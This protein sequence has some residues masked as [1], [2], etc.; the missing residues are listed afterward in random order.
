M[1]APRNRASRRPKPSLLAR[2]SQHEIDTRAQRVFEAALPPAWVA[3]PLHEPDYGIDYQLEVF[4]AQQPVALRT[5][6]QLKGTTHLV[7][8]GE[9][10]HFSLA[11]R[12]L[13]TYVD[14][15]VLPVFLVVVDVEANVAYFVFLQR[16][17]LEALKGT[18]WRDQESVTIA[19]HRDDRVDETPRLR[20][21]LAEAHRYNATRRP[22]AIEGAL[23]AEQERL[24]SID[25]RFLATIT[26]DLHTQRVTLTPLEPV[27]FH[28]GLNENVSAEKVRAFVTG[29]RVTLA[30]GELL[31]RGMPLWEHLTTRTSEVRVG[32]DFAC[33]VSLSLQ[34]RSGAH[35]ELVNV[36]ATFVRGLEGFRLEC[37]LPGE[38]FTFSLSAMPPDATGAPNI[39][40]SFSLSLDAWRGRDVRSLPHFES[41]RAFSSMLGDAIA[42][43]MTVHLPGQN[44]PWP[45]FDLPEREGAEAFAR[46]VET[47]R[48]AREIMAALGRPL[49]FRQMVCD[50]DVI[51]VN[52]IHAL[53]TTGEHRGSGRRTVITINFDKDRMDPSV[54]K[55]TDLGDF[56]LRVKGRNDTDT[57]FGSLLEYPVGTVLLTNAQPP[58]AVRGR[59]ASEVRVQI[60]GSPASEFV[61]RTSAGDAG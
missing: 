23:A 11:T 13:A 57:L 2:V 20:A 31:V 51:N 22:A 58:R 8:V 47:L 56:E 12:A 29:E 32:I 3:R 50:E 17:A 42:A 53:V 52:R 9:E 49:V 44:L 48:K 46:A 15:E 60:R 33:T 61:L 26:A 38:L 28:L 30:P 39:R 5:A 14:A 41:I 40:A 4:E 10:I 25:R 1:T 55:K 6:V 45:R 18:G 7:I 16:Y 37:A 43:D 34:G 27:S 59:K 19:L 36:P 54:L 24:Q 21:A 35:A